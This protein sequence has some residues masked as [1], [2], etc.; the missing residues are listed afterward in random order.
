[1]QYPQTEAELGALRRS[2]DSRRSRFHESAWRDKRRRD[3]GC[4]RHCVHRGRPN[5][6]RQRNVSKRL[7]RTPLFCRN[8]EI[9]FFLL[10]HS[11]RLKDISA[12]LVKL[13]GPLERCSLRRCACRTEPAPSSDEWR[14]SGKVL[15]TCPTRSL[16]WKTQLPWST[17]P[18]RMRIS[19][20]PAGYF[21]IGREKPKR[22]TAP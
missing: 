22:K 20:G 7:P 11:S 21:F 13:A 12:E 3:R 10:V 17:C 8:R 16:L 6:R 14:E 5:D 4:N 1:M 2:G 19:S 15:E 18:L 9:Q